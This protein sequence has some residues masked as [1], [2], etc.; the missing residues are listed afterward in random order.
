MSIV[1]IDEFEDNVSCTIGRINKFRIVSEPNNS[2][3]LYYFKVFN[4]ETDE[5]C[6]ISM[7]EEKIIGAD[8]ET[9]KLGKRDIEDIIDFFNSETCTAGNGRA[10]GFSNW[11]L[12]ISANNDEAIATKEEC[13]NM[14]VDNRL[15]MPDYTKLFMAIG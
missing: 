5:F 11:E 2:K 6:R 3:E 7:T 12:L 10:L 9:L 13:P 1:V 14:Y 8:D 15:P 4:E